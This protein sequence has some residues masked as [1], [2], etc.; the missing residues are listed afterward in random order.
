MTGHR[1]SSVAPGRPGSGVYP[2][3]PLGEEHA[4]VPTGRDVEWEPLVDFRRMDVPENT[5]HGAIA[6]A[7]GGEIIH[8]FGGNV[9]VYGRSMMKPLLMKTFAQVLEP[10]LGEE[11]RAIACSSHNGDTEHVA[12][13]QSILTES[14]WGLM[15]CPL[16]VPLV[17][18]GRQVRRPRRWFHTCSG[19]H[20]AILRALREMGIERAGYTLPSAGWF[21]LF[22]EQLRRRLA[23]PEWEPVRVAKDGCGLPTV[24]NTVNELAILFAGLV[25]ERNDDWIWDAMCSNPD[26]IGG[27]NRLDSTII[28]AAKGRVMAKEGADG[29]LGLSIVDEAFPEGLGVVIKIAHGWNSQATWYVA[30]AV[31][32]V[33]GFD[34][35]NPYPLHRQKAFIVPGIVPEV[36]RKRLDEVVTW[37]EWD[38]DTDRFLTDW[39]RYSEGVTRHDPFLNEGSMQE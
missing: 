17:Q 39:R 12:A 38:P 31:L 37:D 6:W 27:F 34:L 33:L 4:D 13:A 2:S 21:P 20:A 28:K 3:T 15:Q 18:F 32:G 30:R 24:S 10:L 14:E 11:Q 36:M 22:L 35:R 25:P 23:E 8:S 7:H 29:L 26:L 19:E 1:P 5:I 9:L 16:D